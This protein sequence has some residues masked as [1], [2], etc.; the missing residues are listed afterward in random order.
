MLQ[1]QGISK[2]FG[3]KQV[4]NGISL[5]LESGKLYGIV[6]ENGSGKSTLLKIIVG[7]WK[8]N[9]GS[10]KA[11]MESLGLPRKTLYDKMKKY[12]LEKADYT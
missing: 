5:N 6:G 11:T 4:L 10:I 12:G 3:K 7:E 9:S 1:L 2:A 8:A